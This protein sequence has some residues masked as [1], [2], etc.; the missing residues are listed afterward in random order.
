MEVVKAA[1][2][3]LPKNSTQDMSIGSYM[4]N[5]DIKKV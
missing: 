4:V 3:R 2:P 5:D 1:V